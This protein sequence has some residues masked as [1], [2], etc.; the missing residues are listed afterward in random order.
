MKRKP[1][2]AFALVSTLSLAAPPSWSQE[3]A[4]EKPLEIGRWYPSLEAGFALAQSGYSDNWSGG[5]LGS[6]VWAFILNAELKVQASP[7]V[8]WSNQLKLAY[9]QTHTQSRD[10]SGGRTW[11]K[12]E[13]STDLLDLE[14]IFRLTLGSWVDPFVSARFESQFQDAT[15]DAGRS[16]SLNPLRFSETAG[17]AR[18][19]VKGEDRSVLT[20][21]GFTFRESSRRFFTGPAPDKATASETTTDGGIELITDVKM[22]VMNDR[23]VWNSKLIFYQPL[24][25]SGKDALEGLSAAQLMAAGLDPDVAGFTTALDVDWEN[26]LTTHVSKILSVSL[27]TRW[28]YD[29][30]DNT[31]KPVPDGAGGLENAGPVRTAVRKAG[32]FKQTLAIG[33]TYRFL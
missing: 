19:F 27:Y 21:L 26:I 15:D 2:L 10:G 14:S 22:P 30:Y 12:P 6:V 28:V 20:R 16:L 11:D 29:K 18:E 3:G 5:D 1:I 13:K 17:I 7:K 23:V 31:V 25:F 24:F 33:V 8:N 4:E 32:Q 9:G